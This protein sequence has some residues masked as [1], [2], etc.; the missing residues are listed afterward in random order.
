MCI[1][2]HHVHRGQRFPYLLSQSLSLK[3]ELMLSLS[4]PVVSEPQDSS[5]LHLP[6]AG[7]MGTIT[8]LN[9]LHGYWDSELMLAWPALFQMN[10]LPKA[11]IAFEVVSLGSSSFISSCVEL[12]HCLLVP[13]HYQ[14]PKSVAFLSCAP[15]RA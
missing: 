12:L 8:M 9:F 1:C 3:L 7:I 5:C 13:K 15:D 14:H 10:S 6:S 4:E 11:T 2:V